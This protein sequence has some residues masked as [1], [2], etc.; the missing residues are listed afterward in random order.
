M[1]TICLSIM[2]AN[3]RFKLDSRTLVFILNPCHAMNAMFI[4]LCFSNFSLTGEKLALAVFGFSFGGWIGLLFSENDG[5]PYYEVL[6]Y[7]IH[8]FIVSWLGI[9]VL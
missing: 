6:V 9:V 8:H 4:Y 2:I 3:I 5:L 7:Y 1:G